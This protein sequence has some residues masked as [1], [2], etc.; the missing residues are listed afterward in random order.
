VVSSSVVNYQ[1][2]L[3]SGSSRFGDTLDDRHQF[4]GSMS[5][6]GS[7]TIN[8]DTTLSGDLLVFTGSAYMSGSLNVEGEF[9][10]P[11]T[12]Q[13]PIISSTGSLVISG[14]NLYLFI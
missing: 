9:V 6:T 8:G 2:L 13:L 3:V 5:V 7:T 10:L 1:T 11:S 4:T 12:N 14:S